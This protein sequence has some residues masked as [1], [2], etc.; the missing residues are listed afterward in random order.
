[1]LVPEKDQGIFYTNEAYVLRWAY[2]ITVVRELEGLTPG[3]GPF[4]QDRKYRKRLQEQKEGKI[5]NGE[6]SVKKKKEDSDSECSDVESDEEYQR[7]LESGGRDRCAYFFW[8][9]M[10]RHVI[11]VCGHMTEYSLGASLLSRSPFS[12][13]SFPSI[14]IF[15]LSPSILLINS[16]FDFPYLFFI[17]P[18]LL[19]LLTLSLPP[20]LLSSSPLLLFSSSPL[21]PPPPLLSSSPPYF[22]FLFSSPSSQVSMP[23]LMRKVRLP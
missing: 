23:L 19:P 16:F 20:L 12:C 6:K 22:S 14:S 4:A 18:F 17:L 2:Q 21:L 10:C 8:Q 13:L 11:L 7:V 5:P 15:D 9:G 1:M 3:S